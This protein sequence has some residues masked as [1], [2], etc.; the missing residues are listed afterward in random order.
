MMNGEIELEIGESTKAKRDLPFFFL[1]QFQ[2]TQTLPHFQSFSPQQ[3]EPLFTLQGAKHQPQPSD[4]YSPALAPL[5]LLFSQALLSPAT[6]ITAS[7]NTSKET[8][9]R[10]LPRTS[11][12]SSNGPATRRAS[13]SARSRP[14]VTLSLMRLGPSL[15][16]RRKSFDTLLSLLVV[17]VLCLTG[18]NEGKKEHEADRENVVNSMTLRWKR[19]KTARHPSSSCFSFLSFSHAVFF[20]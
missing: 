3:F 16:P 2:H 8:A 18:W 7:L 13:S 4:T 1:P 10:P 17:L 20:C 19:D 15:S 14:S 6:T 11:L 12:R 9:C 5:L